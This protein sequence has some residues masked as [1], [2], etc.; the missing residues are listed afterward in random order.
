MA[1]MLYNHLPLVVGVVGAGQ[2]GAG[3]AQVLATKG[4]DVVLC[5]RNHEV[6]EHGITTIRKSLARFVR[7]GTMAQDDSASTLSRITTCTSLDVSAWSWPYNFTC[8]NQGLQMRAHC[9]RQCAGS[10]GALDTSGCAHHPVHATT[11]DQPLL[12]CR[13]SSRQ[14]SWWRQSARTSS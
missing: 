13:T 8:N 9:D 5:D 6:L 1:S 3:I 11:V 14:T 12:A 2:M 4:M 10:S 7:K